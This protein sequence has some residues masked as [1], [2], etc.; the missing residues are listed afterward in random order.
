[1]HKA[2]F[3]CDNQRSPSAKFQDAD[4]FVVQSML[5]AAMTLL[6]VHDVHCMSNGDQASSFAQA[7]DGS[8]AAN[9]HDNLHERSCQ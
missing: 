5:C 8:K 9:K 4:P 6:Y 2:A 3:S 7:Q 1:M